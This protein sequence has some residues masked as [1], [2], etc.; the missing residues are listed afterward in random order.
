MIKV[1]DNVYVETGMTACNVGFLVTKEGILM[2]DTPMRPTDAVKLREEIGKKGE[3]RY[4]VNTEEHADHWQGSYF[5]PGVLITHQVTRDKL[6]EVPV[7]EVIDMVKHMDPAGLPLMGAFQIRLADLTFNENL[8]LHL[9]DHTIQ[10]F[11]LPGHSTGGIGVYIIEE[12]VV[13]TTDI[14]FHKRK[15]WLSE[16]EPSQWLESLRKLGELDVKVVVPGHGEVCGKD[17][18]QEQTGIVK[19]WV[20][21]VQSAIK[22]GLSFEEAIT[23][24]SC[25]DPYPKQ[26]GTPMTEVELNRA[27]ITR[28]YQLYSNIPDKPGKN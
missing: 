23:Q 20:A 15:S 24:V 16:A 25:P 27:I 4:L 22:L 1:T 12:Q 18:L 3:I 21:V 14:V 11:H 17:Y 9:G 28:L 10:L 7:S 26:P 8:T 13:F 6:A 19:K 5:F 2:I